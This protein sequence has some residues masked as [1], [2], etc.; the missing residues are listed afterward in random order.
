MSPLSKDT[1]SIGNGY[2]G[3]DAGA[4]AQQP[5][6]RKTEGGSV[7]GACS[8]YGDCNGGPSE[9]GL[10]DDL[11]PVTSSPDRVPTSRQDRRNTNQHATDVQIV[12]SQSVS[13]SRSYSDNTEGL[14]NE[15]QGDTVHGEAKPHS[16]SSIP[17][18]DGLSDGRALPPS[19][20][21]CL[22]SD[23]NVGASQRQARRESAQLDGDAGSAVSS[24]HQPSE[25]RVEQAGEGADRSDQANKDGE[26]EPMRN[27]GSFTTPTPPAT[28]DGSDSHVTP[29]H[30]RSPSIPGECNGSNSS[31]DLGAIERVSDRHM[32]RMGFTLED[33][34]ID[35]V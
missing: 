27:H 33:R 29:A 24:W 20:T 23:Q 11:A 30:Q 4:R 1:T 9:N 21:H 13:T 2:N 22:P 31:G 35:A 26:R 5:G 7:A 8:A 18:D 15:L 14:H 3:S 19:T 17:N 16:F 28:E 32:E 10:R 12:D 34:G 6:A 25:G